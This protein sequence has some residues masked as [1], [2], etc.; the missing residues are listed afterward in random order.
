MNSAAYLS[1]PKKQTVDLSWFKTLGAASSN[2]L[3]D[4]ST[5]GAVAS[6]S[7]FSDRSI[8]APAADR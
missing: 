8:A 6:W 5:A 7:R 4:Y 3:H 2:R 1:T